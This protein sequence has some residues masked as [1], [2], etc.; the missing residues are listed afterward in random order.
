L[1]RVAP[2]YRGEPRKALTER[3]ARQEWGPGSDRRDLVC[4]SALAIPPHDENPKMELTE[5]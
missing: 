5:A 2:L 3:M 1:S 4:G